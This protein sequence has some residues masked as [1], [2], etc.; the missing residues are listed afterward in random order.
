M[1]SSNN[2]KRHNMHNPLKQF[3]IRLAVAAGL[4]ASATS[5]HA[6]SATATISAVQNG[7]NYDY[8]VILQNTSTTISLNGFWY[9]WIQFFNDLP[10]SPSSANNTLDWVNGLDGNSI[11]YY[12]NGSGT[13]LAPGQS[14]TF[15]FV[16][17][18]TPAAITL[19]ESGESVAYVH[20]GVP[21]AS[22]SSPGDSTGII[23]P[24]LIVPE[25]SSIALLAAGT[26]LMAFSVRYRTMLRRS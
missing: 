1:N 3:T 24:V 13:S 19:G 21:D 7:G 25:P 8:T 5:A 11:Q 22:Q 9:G 17:A 14:A 20:N 6:Q 2:E 10:S 16:D 18:S 15:T 12:N 23:T 26:I 4:A